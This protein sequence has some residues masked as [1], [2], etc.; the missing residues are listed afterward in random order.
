MGEQSLPPRGP[1]SGPPLSLLVS[2]AAPGVPFS[3][4]VRTVLAAAEA[5]LGACEGIREWVSSEPAAAPF[6]LGSLTP[7]PAAQQ[8]PIWCAEAHGAASTEVG[9]L[10]EDEHK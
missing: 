10:L 2:V 3:D 6:P 8:P 5:G 1:S 7:S 9:F 4:T